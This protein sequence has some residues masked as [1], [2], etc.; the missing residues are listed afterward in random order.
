[1]RAVVRSKTDRLNA[2]QFVADL[3]SPAPDEMFEDVTAVVALAG[4]NEVEVA[5]AGD[6]AIEATVA[7]TRNAVT[8][9]AEHS[10]SNVIYLS[11]FHVYGSSVRPGEIITEDTPAQPEHPYSRARLAAEEI[12]QELSDPVI[13]RLTNSVGAPSH[14]DIER[15]T[16]LVNDLCRHVVRD[17]KIVLKSDGTQWRDFVPLSDVVRI[18]A[19]VSLDAL[20]PGIYNLASGRSTTVR[21]VAEMIR[22]HAKSLLGE[23]ATIEGPVPNAEPSQPYTVGVDKLAAAGHRATGTLDDAIDETLRFCVEWKDALT[24]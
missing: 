18:V 8:G 12:A 11:T 5:R 13:F 10:I 24:V 1:M 19:D 9:A 3:R 22:D 4:P 2:E 20:R 23:Q 21:H 14:P 17:G 16:L 6:E 7:V 15:W